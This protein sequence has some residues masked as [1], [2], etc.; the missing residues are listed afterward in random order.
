[1]ADVFSKH[2]LVPSPEMAQIIAATE[3]LI[4]GEEPPPPYT[5]DLSSKPPNPGFCDLAYEE[6]LAN[7]LPNGGMTAS[8]YF[9]PCKSCS[10]VVGDQIPALYK[11]GWLDW[12]DCSLNFRW[13]SHICSEKR[14]ERYGCWICWDYDQKFCEPMNVD[15]WYK[16]MRRH[17][18]VEGYRICKGKTGGMQRRRNC[19]RKD[20]PKIHS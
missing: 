16:H 13:E 7:K 8:E 4:T 15:T 18:F 14:Q 2:S 1:M 3:I 5:T 17:F 12:V 11:R 20:C 6:R 9:L 10:V 19:A